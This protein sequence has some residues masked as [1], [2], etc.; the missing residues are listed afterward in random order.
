MTTQTFTVTISLPYKALAIHAAGH[1]RSKTA[2]TKAHRTEVKYLTMQ[3]ISK[4]GISIPVQKVRVSSEWFM[5]PTPAQKDRYRPTDV[6]NAIGALKAA[7]DGVADSGL[8]VS[9]NHE[10]L[11]I[12]ETTLHRTA[13]GHKGRACIELVIEILDG[14]L[15]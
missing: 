11:V 7:F 15:G 4:A 9:D 1:W 6:Q 12:G 10:H 14:G 3:A 8:I 13:K 2:P 5:G